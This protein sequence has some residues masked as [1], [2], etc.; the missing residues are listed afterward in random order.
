MKTPN[1][2]YFLRYY[3]LVFLTWFVDSI[4]ILYEAFYHFFE[5]SY[6]ALLYLSFQH[7]VF[8]FHCFCN[9]TVFRLNSGPVIVWPSSEPE[10]NGRNSGM[11][12]GISNLGFMNQFQIWYVHRMN[13]V[14]VSILY[15]WYRGLHDGTYNHG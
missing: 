10:R 7:D 3:F 6:K 12:A 8:F 15:C 1:P 13:S 4:V 14:P 2:K 9:E 5:F 11:P